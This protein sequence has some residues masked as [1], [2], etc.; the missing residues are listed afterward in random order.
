[1]MVALNI[2]TV[3]VTNI[4]LTNQMKDELAHQSAINERFGGTMPQPEP[5]SNWSL[6]A[7]AVAKAK[8]LSEREEILIKRDVKRSLDRMFAAKGVWA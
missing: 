6:L 7:V 2:S 1:M 8:R 3:I 4:P 5:V